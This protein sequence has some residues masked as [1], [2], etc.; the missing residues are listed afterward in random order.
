MRAEII[1]PTWAKVTFTNDEELSAVRKALSYKNS[2]ISFQIKKHQENRWWRQKDPDAWQFRLDQLN[3]ELF[4]CLLERRNGEY[5]LRPGSLPWL[6][7]TVYTENKINYPST[8]PIPWH[9]KPEFEPYGYQSQAVEKLIQAKHGNISLPTGCHSRG[10]KILMFDGTLKS[11]E[12]VQVGDKLMGPDG[13]S[14]T[15]LRLVSGTQEMYKICPNIG[16]PF[17]VNKDHV[18]SLKCTGLKKNPKYKS[19]DKKGEVVNITVGEYLKK[20]KYF[21]H[22]HKLYRVRVDSFDGEKKDVP[23]DPYIFGLWLGDG[24][25]HDFSIT[26]IDE[27]IVKELRSFSEEHGFF[28]RK[29]DLS[30]TISNY[31]LNKSKGTDGNYL[32]LTLK[33]LEVFKNKHIPHIYKTSTVENRRKIFA[34]ILDSDGHNHNGYFEITQKNKKLFDDIVFLARSLGFGVNWTAEEKYATNTEEKKKRIYYRAFIRG[35]FTKIP[36]KIKRKQIIKS[37]INRDPLMTGFRVDEAGVD[38]YY[39]FTVDS[40]NLYVMGDFTVTHNCGKSFILLMIARQMGIPTVVVTP[41][42]SIFNELLKEFQTRLGKKYVGGYGDGKKQIDKLITISIG[43]SLTM[44]KES[45]DAYKHFKNKQLMLIDESHTFAANQLE[46]VCHNVLSDVPYR[47][48]VSATQTRGDGTEKLLQSIIGK[49]VLEM[50]LKQAIDDGYLCP[51]NFSIIETFSPSTLNKK[52]PIECKREHLLYNNEVAKIAANIANA[53]ARHGDQSTLILVEELRQIQMLTK[54]LEVPY[55]YVHSA[56]KK[57][58]AVWGLDKVKLQEQVDAFN[59]G[60][61]KVLIGTRAIS[62]GTNM[63]PTHNVINWVGGASEIMTK[64][65]TMGRSTRKLEIS[66]YKNK[67][68]PKPYTQIYDFKIKGQPILDRHLSTRIRY[69]QEA[70][71]NI[72]HISTIGTA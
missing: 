40:D 70:D 22:I 10:T 5:Y 7:V 25:S 62:T 13:S 69:Y 64:Q 52:D 4:S 16:E 6:P 9:T 57:E 27:E 1:S 66:K 2:S 3:S 21:K 67:H 48:F 28:I 12:D 37:K 19:Q 43:K 23:I 35:D 8:K 39:G 14:R 24:S 53:S 72:V 33:E 60:E 30:Y 20:S 68:V 61:I 55:G 17:V 54:L 26:T 46:T 31:D 56:A 11:V 49:N 18:L 15:V 32:N 58:A 36:T 63:Y 41:S 59:E 45:S 34:G 71:G 42:K 44:L 51:L 47:M 29:N 38:R 50:D 65:G